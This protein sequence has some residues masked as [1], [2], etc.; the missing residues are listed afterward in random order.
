MRAPR[1]PILVFVLLL[2]LAVGC[3]TVMQDEAEPPELIPAQAFTVQ[4]ELFQQ[5]RS[6][7]AKI[8]PHF[9]A[10]VM[11]AWPVATTLDAQLQAPVRLTRAA[12][13]EEPTINREGAWVWTGTVPID[14]RPIAFT[15]TGRPMGDQVDWAM[16]IGHP[17]TARTR[18]APDAPSSALPSASSTAFTPEDTSSSNDAFPPKGGMTSDESPFGEEPASDSLA[19]DSTTE[20]N[21]S[22]LPDE[23]ASDEAA[24]EAAPSALVNDLQAADSTFVLYTAQTDRNGQ[25][26]SW[27]LYD[28]VD[29]KR[30]NVLNARFQIEKATK[31]KVTLDV[32]TA[33]PEHGGDAV[34]YAHDGDQRRLNWTRAQAGQT[35]RVTWNVKSHQG[36]ITATNYNEGQTACWGNDLDD[37]T[38]TSE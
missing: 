9:M 26:G 25:K 6:G 7:T 8:G 3:D 31:K 37:V 19:T 20:T 5:S 35:H 18:Q 16:E 24:P 29:G 30:T 15:L 22:V 17:E 2:A 11:R 23:R 21:D 10:A 1:R 4:T 13:N 14:G 33:A 36:A 34:V 38:C 27:R 28:T 32:P 12:L